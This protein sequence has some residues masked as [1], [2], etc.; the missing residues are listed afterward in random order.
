M[1]TLLLYLVIAEMVEEVEKEEQTH[2][3]GSFGTVDPGK[4][5]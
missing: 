5:E 3:V 1:I 4:K 2:H